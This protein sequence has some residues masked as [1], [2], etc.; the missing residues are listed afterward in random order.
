MLQYLVLCFSFSAKRGGKPEDKENFISLIK[1]L[2]P[3]IDM[4]RFFTAGKS[5]T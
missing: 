2:L 1:V 4:Q 5:L 3:L